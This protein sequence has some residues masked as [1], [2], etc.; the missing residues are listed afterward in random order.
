MGLYCTW[1]MPLPTWLA[2]SFT[3]AH[4]LRP[5]SKERCDAL[6]LHL[7]GRWCAALVLHDLNRKA[8]S[9]AAPCLSL[10]EHALDACKS[11]LEDDRDKIQGGTWPVAEPTRLCKQARLC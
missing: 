5:S 11:E 2:F 8:G 3:G 10:V 4:S 6:L 9:G 1:V 7:P